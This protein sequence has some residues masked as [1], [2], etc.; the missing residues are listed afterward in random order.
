MLRSLHLKNLLSFGPDTEAIELRRLNVLIGPNGSGKSNFLE[1]LSLLQAAPKKI[2][3]PIR[4]GGGVHEWLWKRP[5][6]LETHASAELEAVVEMD[7]EGDALR[8]SIEFSHVNGRFLLV[9]ERVSD[10]KAFT[11]WGAAMAPYVDR[12]EDDNPPFFN[13]NSVTFYQMQPVRR[14]QE[15]GE[16]QLD[17][18]R[19]VLAQWRGKAYPELTSL[20]QRYEAIRLYRDWTFG[21]R[22]VARIRQNN[23][24]PTDFLEP[25]SGNL[26]AVLAE[27]GPP[28][29]R[30][31]MKA[32]GALF[33]DIDD[34][35]VKPV[36]GGLQVFVQ[37]YDKLIPASRLSDGTLRYLSLLAVLCHPRPPPLVAIEEPELGLHPDVLPTLAELLRAASEK[38]QLIVTTHSTALVDAM[39]DMPDSVL[40]CERDANG[41]RME[42]LEPADLKPWLQ[43]YRLGQ[44][45]MRGELGGTRW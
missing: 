2:A 17:P 25:D 19:S 34:V 15:P 3:D 28:S 4:S 24:V 37:Q 13:G 30:E 5:A 36:G 35:S 26:A 32:L 8:H 14:V 39:T 29:K 33:Q 41:T 42:R 6:E 38:T 7:R 12:A 11:N 20:A 10:A 31:L 44:L 18:E 23:D 1:A 45:W 9:N 40:I 27:F 21:V 22:S 43:D 16:P